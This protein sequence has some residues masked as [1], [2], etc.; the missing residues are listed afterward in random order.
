MS[1][2]IFLWGM[3]LLFVVVLFPMFGRSAGAATPVTHSCS[4]TSLLI[5]EPEEP[6]VAAGDVAELFLIENT[7]S[8]SCSLIGFP[9]IAFRSAKRVDFTIPVIHLLRSRGVGG[10]M[11][12]KG[13]PPVSIL[14][15]RGG[16]A[17]FWIE[18]TDE[19]IHDQNNKLV[20]CFTSPE[21]L[22][23]P[24]GSHR[25]TTVA[26]ARGN[27]FYWCGRI[28]VLPILPGTSGTYPPVPL[29]RFF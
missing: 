2:R 6:I 20:N 3:A 19:P 16:L 12:R 23:V 7:G 29:S 22:A 21:M 13:P 27:P 15:S 9:R 25:S 28:Y 24:P 26:A 1:R 5:T 4:V 11:R 10:G 17:S 14:V 8:N 18:G